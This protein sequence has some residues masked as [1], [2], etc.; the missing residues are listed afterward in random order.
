MITFI[1]L[2]NRMELVK[3]CGKSCTL[4][5]NR[6][7]KK[8]EVKSFKILK[9]DEDEEEN[10]Q[11]GEDDTNWDEIK[12]EQFDV[13]TGETITYIRVKDVLESGYYYSFRLELK[14]EEIWSDNK[15]MKGIGD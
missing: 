3:N 7:L 14:D 11:C 4:S 10:G 9:I 1:F 6:V 2:I 5:I 15:N 13:I 12:I 8:D